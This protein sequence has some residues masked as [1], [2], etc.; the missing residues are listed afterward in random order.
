MLLLP[1][2]IFQ[3]EKIIIIIVL[4]VSPRTK[5]TE[6]KKWSLRREFINTNT[7]FKVSKSNMR[8][9]RIWILWMLILSKHGTQWYDNKNGSYTVWIKINFN[10][11][12]TIDFTWVTM[13]ERCLI[14]IHFQK[15]TF[16]SPTS[17]REKLN[18]RTNYNRILT[19][20]LLLFCRSVSSSTN[21]RLKCLVYIQVVIF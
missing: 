12:R 14:S 21:N 16:T 19:K 17:V 11:L 7:V 3:L 15:I 4:F 1:Q 13:S 10:H 5:N 8:W 2:D 20:I 18:I 6:N 9:K